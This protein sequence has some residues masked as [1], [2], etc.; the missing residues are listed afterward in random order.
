MNIDPDIIKILIA[1]GVVPEAAT[2]RDIAVA[3]T[4]L[5]RANG[6]VRVATQ[7]F[8]TMKHGAKQ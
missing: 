6:N 5:A 8:R 7:M 1:A 2:Q 4:M 3:D